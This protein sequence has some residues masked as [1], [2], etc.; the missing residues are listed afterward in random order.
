MA[1]EPGVRAHVRVWGARGTC[2]SPG[3]ATVRVGGHTS[4]VE[5]RPPDGRLLVFDAGTG[6]RALGLSLLRDR[7]PADVELF[8]THRH[9]DHVMGLPYFAPLV[10][11]DRAVRIR[12]GNG[13]AAAL[14][15]LID[16]LLSPPLFPAP[17]GLREALTIREFGPA[18]DELVGP[19]VRVRAIP[20]HHPGGAAVLC[21]VDAGGVVVA[22]APDNE[23]ALHREDPE[24]Q[25]VRERLLALLRGVP[26]LVHDATYSDDEVAAHAGWGHSSAEEATRF[27]LACGAGRLLLTHH[28][29]D[30]DDDAVTALVARCRTLVDSAGAMLQVDAAC[31][32]MTVAV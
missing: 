22:F 30:R 2:P 7:D 24:A 29:P 5:V 13:D 32:G 9:A 17:D 20:A 10:V 27:A 1:G 16:T 19:D 28:H 4:C 12:C 26:L 25:A 21:L 8:L 31:D 6:L 15:Q 3:P 11:R 23:L 18:G 14:A